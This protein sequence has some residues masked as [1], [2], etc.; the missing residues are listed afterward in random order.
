MRPAIQVAL[1]EPDDSEP[2]RLAS[3]VDLIRGKRPLK[4]A[5]VD[6]NRSWL[7][8][9]EDE[10]EFTTPEGPIVVRYEGR[11]VPLD[12]GIHLEDFREETYPGISMAASYESHVLV[13]PAVGTE[14]PHEIKMNHPLK[15]AGYTF[16]QASF[17]RT[18][19]GEEITVLSVARDPG[20]QVSFFGYCVLSAGLLLIFF[21]KPYFRKLDDRIARSRTV[22][23]EGARP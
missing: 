6:P 21:V 4:L 7:F 10:V 23:N 14:F 19:Q 2:L 17:Q 13:R 8:H 16:Y 11:T 20:M 9:N 1:V 18:P 3:V 22:R 5:S 12:F 15:H